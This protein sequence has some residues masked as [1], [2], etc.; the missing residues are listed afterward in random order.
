MCIHMH[1]TSA[2]GYLIVMRVLH[3]LVPSWKGETPPK[4]INSSEGFTV[5]W[6]QI[7]CNQR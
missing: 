7:T 1:L 2:S 4:K 5:K 6:L 3:V